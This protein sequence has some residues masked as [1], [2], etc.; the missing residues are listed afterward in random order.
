MPE[1]DG[2]EVTPTGDRVAAAPTAV[3]TTNANA[4]SRRTEENSSSSYGAVHL[5]SNS[6]NSSSININNSSNRFRIPRLNLT[7][8][9]MRSFARYVNVNMFSNH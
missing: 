6:R 7:P 2:M 4:W 8:S 5:P 3:T 1:T 9:T